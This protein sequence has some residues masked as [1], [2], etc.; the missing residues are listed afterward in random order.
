MATQL[1]SLEEAELAEGQEITARDT[2]ALKWKG[3]VT[4]GSGFVAVPLALL[5]LQ[6]EYGLSATDMLVLI[7]LLVHWWAP[8]STVFPRNNV[9]ARRMGVD[10][11]TV[12]RSTKKL[13]EAGLMRRMT[14]P[15]GKRVFTFDML[16]ERVARDLM[17]SFVVERFKS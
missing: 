15:D 7:N 10:P 9:I 4:E 5:R 3:A 17:R 6:S 13:I 1:T 2:V 12:Q 16:A 8:E 11:R 14:A